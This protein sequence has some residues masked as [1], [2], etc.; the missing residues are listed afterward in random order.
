MFR[1]FSAGL[2]DLWDG[3]PRELPP[4]QPRLDLLCACLPYRYSHTADVKA[5]T[6]SPRYCHRWL[7]LCLCQQPASAGVV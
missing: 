5:L 7:S 3:V 2:T 6:A 4:L 1:Y